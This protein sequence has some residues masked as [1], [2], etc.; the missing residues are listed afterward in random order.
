MSAGA[1]S[2]TIPLQPRRSSV[3]ASKPS[4]LVVDDEPQVLV[5]LEDMLSDHFVVHTAN[6]PERALE[7]ASARRE[8]AVVISDQRMPK[9]TGDQLF[10]RLSHDSQAQ[11]ILVT[12]FADL[13]AVIRAVNEG[14][15][16]AYITKPWDP[17]DLQQKVQRAAEHFRLAMELAHER[18]LLSDLMENMPDGIY[19]KD[20]DLRFIKANAPVASMLNRGLE[21]TQ[22]VGQRLSDLS[23]SARAALKV[24][25]EEQRILR[26]GAQLVDVIREYGKD[27]ARQWFSE[28]KAPVRGPSGA[29]IGL[30][31]ISRNVTDRIQAENAR[32][33]QQQRIARLTRIHTVLSGVNSAIVRVQERD[34]LLGEV[35]GLAV[36]EGQLS[37]ATITAFEEAT[38]SFRVVASATFEQTEGWA[39]VPAP[40]LELDTELLLQVAR[41]RA[42]VVL[43]NTASD[44]GVSIAPSLAASEQRAVAAFPL[45]ASGRLEYVFALSSSQVGF[46]DSDEVHLLTDLA[47]NISFA[48]SHFAT[49]DRLDFLAY[50]DELT[51]LPNRG[52]LFDRL[53][54][55]I[56]TSRS[57]KRKLALLLLDI[58]RFRQINETLGRSGGDALLKLVASRLQNGIAEQGSLARV[59]GNRFAMLMPLIDDEADVGSLVENLLS[60]ILN[61]SF[62]I[63][64][65]EVLISGR[66]GISLYPADGNDAEAL[67]YNAE[68]ALKKAKSQGRRYAFY[69]PS[70]N[71]QVAQ[72]L[73]LETRLRRALEN[74]EFVLHYQPK[75]E[76]RRGTLVGLE[77]LIRWQHPDDGL[78][79]PG[80]FIPI[81]EETGLIMDVGRW[82]LL[83]AA[84]QHA[85]WTSAGLRP[86]RIAVN[87]SALQLGQPDF[88]ETLEQVTRAH[89]E[90]VRE[91]D[92]E[93]TESVFV[94]DLMGNVSKL[95]AARERGL[96]VAIDDF[97]TGY[98]SLGYLSRL[99][100][101]I[102]KIDRS[103]I[104]RMTKD[105]QDM[106]LVTTMISLAHSLDCKVVAEGVEQPEQAQL[107]HLLRCDQ[108]QGWLTGK[109]MVPA[110]V[111]AR[112][113]GTHAFAWTRS[114]E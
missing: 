12:G 57:M 68:A 81:L 104:A 27:S 56:A 87:V 62:D 67:L 47:D 54:Q 79:P 113:G 20:L 102:L 97:G 112:F 4:I 65:T 82:V 2:S 80:V 52:L 1:Q 92:L 107:L 100:I 72:K 42:P 60:S 32:E 48:L 91:L 9:M 66:F 105:P 95:E 63:G 39:Q 44:P 64:D 17:D 13:T 38:A 3:P 76:L 10:Q 15:I 19:F 25:A 73:T 94:D 109:P 26:E 96:Q 11:R 58:D 46:F 88:L 70:M 74:S 114:D 89:P 5:A 101:D 61:T 110:D 40:K 77:A 103:F 41:T 78:I 45:F 75:L 14:R 49:K 23:K 22:L 84:T 69:A 83:Q 93:I 6:S 71:D 24:E 35:C 90:A 111:A 99:P 98:S 43:N 18:Q 86:P 108:V 59:D 31:G 16:F 7:L 36:R 37:L 34:R 55:Q 106:S 85:E 50:Y 29:V 51:G 30:V 21:A 28:T 53:T 33:L 8:I